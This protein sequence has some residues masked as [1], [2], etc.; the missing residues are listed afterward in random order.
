M[1]DCELLPSVLPANQTKVLGSK[2]CGKRGGRSFRHEIRP[3]LKDEF[4]PEGFEPCGPIHES[5]PL[6]DK[7]WF[8]ESMT[9]VEIGEQSS[10]PITGLTFD[11]YGVPDELWKYYS[12]VER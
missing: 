6:T 11:L 3:S 12:Y 10:C 7:S 1:A 9:C 8:V 4:C 5:N 2:I